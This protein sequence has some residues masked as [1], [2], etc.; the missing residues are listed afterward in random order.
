MA[1]KIDHRHHVGR[2]AAGNGDVAI[3]DPPAAAP[4]VPSFIGA[5]LALFANYIAA[6]FPAVGHYG[7]GMIADLSQVG[8]E[9][10]LTHPGR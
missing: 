8:S 2:A 6:S 1:D 4:L 9:P 3:F 5:N 7:S 10:A